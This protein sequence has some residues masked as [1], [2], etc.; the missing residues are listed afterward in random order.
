MLVVLGA[1]LL[2]SIVLAIVV[3]PILLLT[4]GLLLAIAF[5]WHASAGR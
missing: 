1:L 5:S 2:A 4:A 3:A